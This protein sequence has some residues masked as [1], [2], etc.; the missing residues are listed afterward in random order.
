MSENLLNERATALQSALNDVPPNFT[1][2]SYA[3]LG[4]TMDQACDLLQAGIGLTGMLVECVQQTA[5]RG[6]QGRV[7]NSSLGNLAFTLVLPLNRVQTQLPLVV[8]CAIHKALQQFTGRKF[9]IKWPNDILSEDQKKI[10]GV[11]IERKRFGSAQYDLIGVGLNVASA[12]IPELSCSL[13]D[14]GVLVDDPVELEALVVSSLLESAQRFERE[15]FE[16]FYQYWLDH[17]FSIGTPISFKVDAE[18]IFGEFYGLSTQGEL[19]LKTSQGELVSFF[20]G[21]IVLMQR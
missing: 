11:L 12:P 6:R 1:V 18:P 16:S 3:E 21:D 7:W 8:S 4:S 19:L 17:T 5:G 10:C 15:G 2:H 13:D 20:S 9:I 14:L